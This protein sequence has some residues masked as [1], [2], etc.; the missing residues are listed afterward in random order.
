L[1][2]KR[3]AH[4]KGLPKPIRTP[5]RER[6]RLRNGDNPEMI[7]FSETPDASIVENLQVSRTT[8]KSLSM[9]RQVIYYYQGQRP[10]VNPVIT[11]DM[12]DD[13]NVHH[14]ARLALSPEV[15]R[16]IVALIE[17]IEKELSIAESTHNES[18]TKSNLIKINLHTDGEKNIKEA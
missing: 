13:S 6:G 8:P 3:N 5:I 11:V 10:Y 16:A 2:A 14:A 18:G 4:K 12:P 1:S 7:S 9:G 15:N 17:M